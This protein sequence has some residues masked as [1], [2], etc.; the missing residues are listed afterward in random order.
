MTPDAYV[1]VDASLAIKVVVREPDSDKAD[2][3]FACCRV[4]RIFNRS[5]GIV[6]ADS[7]SR[8]YCLK[9]GQHLVFAEI[10][11][12]CNRSKH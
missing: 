5:E 12:I 6:R 4:N 7:V 1:C 3:L 8:L 10:E 11:T 2:A 9:I